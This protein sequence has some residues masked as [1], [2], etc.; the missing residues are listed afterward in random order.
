M[1]E[2]ALVALAV[3]LTRSLEKSR[4]PWQLYTC[5][6][7][8]ECVL[9]V[10]GANE[11]EVPPAAVLSPHQWGLATVLLL[12]SHVG[13]GILVRVC[14]RRGSASPSRG[15]SRRRGLGVLEYESGESGT[16][17]TACGMSE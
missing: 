13:S 17:M 3:L 14:I 2:K 4:Q 8:C 6:R 5:P 9:K 11:K 15:S 1:W 12:L 10:A 16:P 7:E